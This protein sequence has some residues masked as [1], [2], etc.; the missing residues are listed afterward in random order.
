GRGPSGRRRPPGRGGGRARA[1]CPVPGRASVFWGVRGVLCGVGRPPRHWL[2][3]RGARRPLLLVPD[4]RPHAALLPADLPPPLALR[5]DAS[6]AGGMS[7]YPS[8]GPTAPA[9]PGLPNRPASRSTPG[10]ANP[11]ARWGAP[12]LSIT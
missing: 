8:T 11:T 9:L 2:R 10:T 7:S 5:H 6:L 3:V 1:G 4:L 12:A